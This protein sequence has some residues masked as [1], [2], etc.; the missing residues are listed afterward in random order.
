MARP[1]PSLTE[2]PSQEYQALCEAIPAARRPPPSPTEVPHSTY[3]AMRVAVPSDV[4]T[5]AAFIRARTPVPSVAHSSPMQASPAMVT[6]NLPR[7]PPDI[8]EPTPTNAL[9]EQGMGA[10]NLSQVYTDVTMYG[11]TLNEDNTLLPASE[12]VR[13]SDVFQ[14]ISENVLFNSSRAPIPEPVLQT[15]EE[16]VEFFRLAS[17]K[18]RQRMEN[19]RSQSIELLTGSDRLQAYVTTKNIE[20]A[21]GNM[22]YAQENML[23]GAEGYSNFFL[24]ENVPL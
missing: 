14:P 23:V 18:E 11:G 17:D 19:S 16:R 20:D 10:P 4:A 9:I 22:F 13:N 5:N 21:E 8:G 2:V 7:N 15:Q 12:Q 24:G 3:E 6:L 1:P